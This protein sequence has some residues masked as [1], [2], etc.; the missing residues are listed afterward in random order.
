MPNPYLERYRDLFVLGCLTGF[1]FSNYSN[2]K[3]KDVRNDLLYVKQAKALATV[4]VLL[5][6]EAKE[7][8]FDKYNMQMRQVSNL[9]FNYRIIILKK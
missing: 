3:P 6:K 9:N 4:V 7:T 5:R 2:I 1:R 8:L